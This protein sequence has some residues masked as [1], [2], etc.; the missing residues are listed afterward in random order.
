MLMS[1]RI[2]SRQVNQLPVVGL[3]ELQGVYSLDELEE[4][5]NSVPVFSSFGGLA[6]RVA[7][8]DRLDITE[9]VNSATRLYDRFDLYIQASNHIFA[10]VSALKLV[11]LTVDDLDP[12]VRSI[13]DEINPSRQSI[14]RLRKNVIERMFKEITDKPELLPNDNK[15]DSN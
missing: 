5:K 13:I 6:I 15:G 10:A 4:L 9:D 2:T 7:E 8:A 11:G 12:D 14:K 3:E 1:T